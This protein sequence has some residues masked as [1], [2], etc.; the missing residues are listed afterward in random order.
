[1]QGYAGDKYTTMVGEGHISLMPWNYSA[2]TAG[3]WVWQASANQAFYG[4][5]NNSSNAQ[6][7]QIDY[8]VY[9]DVGT[10]T[11]T[12][13]TILDTSRAII[14]LLIDGGSVGTVDCYA[15]TAY[16]SIKSISGIA[17]TTAGLKTISMKAA[18]RHASATQWYI[19]SSGISLYRTA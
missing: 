18:S 10:Y 4:S 12:N 5:Y 13:L 7:D 9:L 19:Y 6:N 1:M 17:I 16:N 14:T 3:T 15:A 11:F 8:K 2:I